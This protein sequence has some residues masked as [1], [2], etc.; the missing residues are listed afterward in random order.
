MN[1][2]Q[3]NFLRANCPIL[4]KDHS[5]INFFIKQK[6]DKTYIKEVIEAAKKDLLINLPDHYILKRKEEIKFLNYLLIN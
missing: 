1:I 5:L 2:K 6:N 3:L 4:S